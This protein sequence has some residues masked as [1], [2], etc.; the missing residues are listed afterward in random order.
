MIIVGIDWAK[1]KHDIAIMHPH[2]AVSEKLV[3]KHTGAGLDRLAAVIAGYESDPSQVR[4]AVESHDGA[5]LAWLLSQRYQ[6]FALNPKSAQRARDRYRPAGGKDD[7]SDAFI[8]ADTL[9]LDHGT[10]RQLSRTDD[11][12]IELRTVGRLRAQRVRERVALVLRLRS[13]LDQWCPELSALCNDF[14]IAWQRHFLARFPL[15]DDL[16]AVHG[17]TVNAFIRQ[18]RMRR[19]TQDRIHNLRN[20]A[21]LHVPN[22]RKAALRMDI[23]FMVGQIQRMTETIDGLERELQSRVQAHE[24][25]SI[26]ESLPA[27]GPVVT[28][29]LLAAFSS[30]PR[31]MT[32]AQRAAQWGVAPLTIASGRSRHVKRRRACDGYIRDALMFFAFNTAMRADCWAKGYYRR[33]RASGATHY[34]ALRCLA[35]RWVKII[36]KMYKDGTHYDEQRHRERLGLNAV[37]H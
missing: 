17:N 32:H 23:V 14:D 22:A 2:G 3:V 24:H 21:G 34:G 1:S 15:L 6:V 11:L 8:I 13:L 20:Q 33:K 9:R 25:V 29:A 19:T 28:S 30:C 36:S 7:R 27:K 35:Q 26:F 37:A 10:L 12:A 16:Q 18:H 31:E 4:V 5:L